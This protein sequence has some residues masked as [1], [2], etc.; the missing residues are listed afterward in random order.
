[1]LHEWSGDRYDNYGFVSPE[2]AEEWLVKNEYSSEAIADAIGRDIDEERGPGQPAIGT[3]VKAVIP[4]DQVVVIDAIVQSGE[5]K[6][7][8][9]AIRI[10]VAEALAARG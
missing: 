4:D 7:R 3:H 5:V 1:V 6:S 2:V 9:E 10:L 8:S